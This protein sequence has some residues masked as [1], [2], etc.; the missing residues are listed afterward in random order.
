MPLR[1]SRRMEARLVDPRDVTI[2]ESEPTYRCSFWTRS[3][4]A[5]RDYDITGVESVVEVIAWADASVEKHESYVL[6]VLWEDPLNAGAVAYL[7]L[8]GDP[9]PGKSF[10]DQSG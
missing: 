5:C 7:R 1:D 10:E 3:G 8:I 4:S 9:P 2:E 6:G